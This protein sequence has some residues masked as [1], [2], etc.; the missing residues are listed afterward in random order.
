[1]TRVALYTLIFNKADIRMYIYV[2]A[3]GN[4]AMSW[5]IGFVK[6]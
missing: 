5:L 2:Y 4:Y 6:K 3:Y 1:M